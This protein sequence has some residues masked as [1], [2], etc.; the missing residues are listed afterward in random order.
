MQFNFNFTLKV[1]VRYAKRS[2]INEIQGGAKNKHE[3]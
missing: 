1:A 2:A 3:S